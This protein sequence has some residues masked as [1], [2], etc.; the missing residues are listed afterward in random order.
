MVVDV[1]TTG[2]SRFDRIIEIAAVQLHPDTWEIVDEYETLVNPE[3]DVGPTWVHGITASMVEMA[4]VFPEIVADVARRLH[5]RVIVAHNLP[6]DARLLR[7]EL[8]RLDVRVD[9][10]AGV[11]TLKA[12]RQK[13]GVACEERGI[14]LERA[15]CALADARATAVLARRLNL[16]AQRGAK[17]AMRIGYIS[18][19]AGQRTLRREIFDGEPGL[20]RR[21]VSRAHY[22][23]CDEAVRQYL[24]VL[25]RVLDDGIID[26]SERAE[27][28]ALS[29]EWGIP[30]S[31][32]Q[33]AHRSYFDCIVAA[34]KRDGVITAGERRVMEDVARQ[35]GISEAVIP[36]VTPLPREASM[37]AGRRVCFTGAGVAAGKPRDRAELEAIAARA[38][39]KP[40]R[41]VTRKGCDLLVAADVSSA[42]TK[43]RAARRHGIPIV[44]VSRF[45]DECGD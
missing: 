18:H 13:L 8:E 7:Q 17:R 30:E 16:R 19:P 34:A 29:E 35:L 27:L 33:E 3:R 41:S 24:D 45:L 14:A 4:P 38:G 23:H 10:G 21:I 2:F 26:P 15:H 43:A 12:T 5:G 6:F 1:E 32:R 37:A 9:F 11:C 28:R 40:V 31:A 22:P 44:S 36:A 42:S 25:D 39:L 20:M